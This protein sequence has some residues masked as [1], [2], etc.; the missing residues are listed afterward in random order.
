MADDAGVGEQARD[1]AR[2]ESRHTI[3]VEVRERLAEVRTLAEN[4]QPTEA[5]L[6]S[7]ETDLFK[8]PAVVR[9]RR[10][11]FPVVIAQVERI[12]ARPPAA[13]DAVGVANQ[14]IRGFHCRTI[15]SF[16]LVVSRW[17]LVVEHEC[18]SSLTSNH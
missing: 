2:A 1:V 17:R 7:L 14:T 11:P 10:A 18:H 4:R 12:L 13:R 5:G 6:E 15:E 8:Q 16:W 3:D 9:H